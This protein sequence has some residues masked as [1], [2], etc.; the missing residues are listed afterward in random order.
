V[1]FVGGMVSGVIGSNGAFVLASARMSVGVPGVVA[2]ASN[3]AHQFLKALVGAY[4][5]S[6]YG[7]VDL[8]LGN[9]MDIFSEAGVL[10]GKHVMVTS[11]RPSVERGPI[12]TSPSFIWL[13][14]ALPAAWY[15]ATDGER[16]AEK[17]LKRHRTS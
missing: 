7:Q 5:R 10:F 3:M 6:K 11:A 2:V 12:A 4:K 14:L 16:S 17:A 9:I 15:C 8:K 1:A 13:C